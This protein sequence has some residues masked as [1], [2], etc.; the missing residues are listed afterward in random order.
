MI[1]GCDWFTVRKAVKGRGT[2]QRIEGTQL[3]ESTRVLLVDDV[4]TRGDSI[5]QA[6]EQ[7]RATGATIVAAVTLVDRGGNANEFFDA[8]GVFYRPLVTYADLGIEPVGRGLL[9]T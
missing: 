6:Y 2:N 5:K 1:T 4:V 7:I 8:E 3:D 9:H